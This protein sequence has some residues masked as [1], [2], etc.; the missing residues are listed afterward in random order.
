[1]LV[2]IWPALSIL[3]HITRSAAVLIGPSGPMMARRLAA[4][5]QRHRRQV[6]R[7]A[8]TERPVWPAGEQQVIERQ[9]GNAGPQPPASPKNISFS[10]GSTGR[11]RDQQAREMGGVLR[12]LD[13][14]PVAGGEDRGQRRERQV[15]RKVPRH[16]HA[17]HAQ[18]LQD[19]AVL[20]Q[21]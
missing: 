4:E 9:R 17:D 1:M 18:R 10:G 7:A 21:G 6:A 19:Q 8:I 3:S 20:R 11:E 16:D 5:L 15:E 12:H 14:R 13:H 2:Q